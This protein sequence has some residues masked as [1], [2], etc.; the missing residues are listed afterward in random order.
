MN[1]VE[2]LMRRRNFLAFV[3]ADPVSVQFIRKDAPEPDAAGGFKAS[4]SPAT[5]LQ[6]QQARIVHNTRRY[7]NGLVN[8]EA[9]EI[10]LTDYL[11]LGVHT[12]NVEV[13]DQFEWDD[14]Q[15]NA[16]WYKITGIHPFRHESTLCSIEFVGPVNRNG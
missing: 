16:G 15:G 5:P 11:L 8:A 10:P 7:K 2:L 9:G 13:D 12:L 1:H 14:L 6:P 3:K 4:S